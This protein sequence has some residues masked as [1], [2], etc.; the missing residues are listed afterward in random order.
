MSRNNK[1]I[2]VVLVVVL[3]ISITIGYAVINTT[4]NINGKSNISKNTWDIYFDNIKIT[5]G[6][7]TAVKI[8]N[9]TKDWLTMACEY[10]WSKYNQENGYVVGFDVTV[11]DSMGDKIGNTKFSATKSASAALVEDFTFA[12]TESQFSDRKRGM[13]LQSTPGGSTVPC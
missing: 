9:A 2:Y 13:Y 3:L 5:N 11:F 4:L 7:V 12:I 6:S 8:P 10:D 1:N